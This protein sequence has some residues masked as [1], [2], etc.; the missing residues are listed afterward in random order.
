MEIVR[1]T[2]V[3]HLKHIELL[4]REY[5]EFLGVDLSF[6]GFEAE[7]EKLPGK[8][9]GPKGALLLA[10]D[11]IAAMGCVAVR[12]LDGEECEMKRLYVKPENRGNGL[13][14]RLA[15]GIIEEA[16]DLGYSLM[17]LD[18]LVRLK[19]A[20]QLYESLGFNKT[21]LYYDNPLSGVEYWEL[22]L[23]KK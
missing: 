11:G 6:Q 13:G 22:S 2:T 20:M 21:G 15:K 3:D 17:R 14:R 18:T 5:E 4:F 12:E 19:E 8:Y 9:A 1:V 7:V 10:T 16:V 23:K